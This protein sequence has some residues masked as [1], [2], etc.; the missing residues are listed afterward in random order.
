MHK[1]DINWNDTRLNT[2]LHIFNAPDQAYIIM[3]GL[4][5]Y[6]LLLSRSK[7]RL[8]L[9]FEVALTYKQFYT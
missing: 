4:F 5:V 6:N 8:D 7:R 9:N 1:A 3:G 2:M